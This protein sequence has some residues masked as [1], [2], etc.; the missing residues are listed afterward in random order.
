MSVQ[1]ATSEDIALLIETV[2]AFTKMV[3]NVGSFCKTDADMQCA[4]KCAL[5]VEDINRE[6]KDKKVH[7]L[8]IQQMC[9]T[10]QV[11]EDSYD[12]SKLQYACDTLIE[13]VL[14][15]KAVSSS[16]V[17]CCLNN[18]IELCGKE[19]FTKVLS[20]I[21]VKSEACR[22][23]LDYIGSV[24]NGTQTSI[25]FQ[26][27][28]LLRILTSKCNEAAVIHA[29][30]DWLASDAENRIAVVFQVKIYFL[31]KVK[32]MSVVTLLYSFFFTGY[33]RSRIRKQYF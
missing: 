27:S 12:V 30:Y 1:E 4:F 33:I 21:I 5:R 24:E 3:K 9:K 16:C 2:D 28:V 18:Y 25:T 22:V 23:L 14:T 26:A 20:A 31:D 7:H 32:T 15:N 17:L 6:L 8:F 19:R 11:S 13:A 29:I 10:L